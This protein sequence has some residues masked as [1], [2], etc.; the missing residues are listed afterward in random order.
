[1]SDEWPIPGFKSD[2]VPLWSESLSGWTMPIDGDISAQ[3]FYANDKMFS[4]FI[5]SCC[6]LREEILKTRPVLILLL[7]R[8]DKYGRG[9]HTDGNVVK[10]LCPSC[11]EIIC[12][13]FYS[14]A[15]RADEWLWPVWPKVKAGV[16]HR[17]KISVVIFSMRSI[18]MSGSYCRHLLP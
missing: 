10:Q 4:S 9:T 5:S 16:E 7:R 13:V 17:R 3:H 14:Q 2:D 1:M 6:H 8:S 12:F 15:N 11:S 18:H